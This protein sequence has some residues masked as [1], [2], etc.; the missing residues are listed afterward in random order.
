MGTPP[1]SG[2]S[3]T[4]ASSTWTK[5]HEPLLREC[6]LGSAFIISSPFLR[7]TLNL[8]FHLAPTPAPYVVV[9]TVDA[10]VMWA[11]TRLKQTGFSEQAEHIR[12]RYFRDGQQPPL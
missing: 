8:L 1:W 12:L 4:S 11:V 10:A 6:L 2:R 7:L 5:E 3:A 9:A